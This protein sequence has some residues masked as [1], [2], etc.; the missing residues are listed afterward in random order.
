MC[1][2][3]CVCVRVQACVSGGGG[4]FILFNSYSGTQAEG[5]SPDRLARSGQPIPAVLKGKTSTEE[6]LWKVDGQA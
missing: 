6:D 5:N 4:G 2:C 1:A 3:A